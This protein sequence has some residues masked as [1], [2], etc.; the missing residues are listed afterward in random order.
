[1]MNRK[2][3]ASVC[4]ASSVLVGCTAGHGKYTSDFKDKA[5]ARMTGVRA[6]TQYDMAQQQYL[7]GDLDK[8]LKTIESSIMLRDD[9][10]K[11]HL[12]RGRI[13]LEKGNLDSAMDSLDT[14]L[15]INESFADAHYFQG[16]IHERFNRTDKAI[17]SFRAAYRLDRT[18]AQYVIALV[19]M[20]IEKGELEQAQTL[21]ERSQSQFE[22]NP[23]VHQTLGHIAMMRG[24]FDTAVESFNQAHL[25]ASADGSILEDLARAQFASGH[26]AEAEYS[27]SQLMQDKNNASRRDLRLLW[28]RTLAELDR[29]VEARGILRTLLKDA[30]GH[31]DVKAWIELGN[32]A[33]I[34]GDNDELREAGHRLSMI[35]PNRFEGQYLLGLYMMREGNLE[36]SARH[37]QRAVEIAPEN[38]TPALM[39]GIVF[40]NMGRHDEARQ[41]FQTALA[42]DP[43]DDRVMALLERAQSRHESGSAMA[44][45]SEDNE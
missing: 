33:W 1:M 3:I 32:V 5:N 6:A 10:A 9:V 23:A 17:E 25:L 4:V 19:E 44:T 37:L 8:A 22:L 13:F 30:G 35:A 27:F 38:A 7:S 41:F 14:A 11:S 20:F 40:E 34:L 43:D 42:L 29:P 28:A 18:D 2:A 16:I 26:F 24:E 21:L 39:L 12:L 31:K 45:V 36:L 15:L